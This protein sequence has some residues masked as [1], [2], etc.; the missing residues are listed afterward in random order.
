MQTSYIDQSYISTC[1]NSIGDSI[2]LDTVRKINQSWSQCVNWHCRYFHVVF[3]ASRN[4]I[5]CPLISASCA[6]LCLVSSLSDFAARRAYWEDI[7]VGL[8]FGIATALYMVLLNYFIIID[9]IHRI[10][11]CPWIAR[12]LIFQLK[13][14]IIF[15]NF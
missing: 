14:I 1:N 7:T 4:N 15:L 9:S 5:L 8:L 12:F 13:K 11:N 6:L 3:R 10:E 2:E